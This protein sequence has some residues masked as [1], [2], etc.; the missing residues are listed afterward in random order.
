[1]MVICLLAQRFAHRGVSLLESSYTISRMGVECDFE[2]SVVHLLHELNVI[3]EEFLLPPAV[4][5][6]KPDTHV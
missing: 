4:R 2:V 5:Q 6:V 3:W 1:M